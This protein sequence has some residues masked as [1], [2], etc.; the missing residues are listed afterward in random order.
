M[1]IEASGTSNSD[2]TRHAP[3]TDNSVK[4]KTV[5]VYNEYSVST[6][7]PPSQ[8]LQPSSVLSTLS[9]LSSTSF[10]VPNSAPT[11]TR[12]WNAGSIY[13]YTPL[14]DPNTVR[15]SP[16]RAQGLRASK[17]SPPLHPSSRPEW[18]RTVSPPTIAQQTTDE[19]KV[20]VSIDFG[21]SRAYTACISAHSGRRDR[22]FG[23]GA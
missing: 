16:V 8:P 18:G 4:L 3:S 23:S 17:V 10:P 9:P 5:S 22:V 12:P 19:G 1:L 14:R 21:K 15:P 11:L 2:G 6:S 13:C 7:I 20:S